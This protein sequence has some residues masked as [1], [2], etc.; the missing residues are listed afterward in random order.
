MSDFVDLHNHVLPIDDG[1]KDWDDA[2]AMLKDAVESQISTVFVTPHII[3]GGRYDP[4]VDVIKTFTLELNERTQ[5]ENLPIE[6]KWGSEFQINSE[7]MDAIEKKR[8]LCYQD[9]SYLLVEF[10][11]PYVH[12]GWVDQALDELVYQGV[13][14]VI[15]HPERYFDDVVDALETSYKWVKQGYHLQVNRNSL[16][17]SAMPMHR[18]MALKLIDAG[19]VH[20]VASDA[21]HAKGKRR[22]MAKDT[23]RILHTYFGKSKTKRLLVDNPHRLMRNEPLKAVKSRLTLRTWMMHLY[24]RYILK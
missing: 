16:F 19:L 12:Y 23:E 22:L 15:A 10:L 13:R 17:R 11:R 24:I 6:V 3:P 2:L 5:K 7:V 14:I 9:T 8:F 18:K 1:A 4:S 20:C 21:H